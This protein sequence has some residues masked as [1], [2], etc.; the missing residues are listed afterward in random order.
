MDGK[1]GIPSMTRIEF[2]LLAAAHLERAE[3]SFKGI[4]KAA[5]LLLLNACQKGYDIDQLMT[6]DD[7]PAMVAAIDRRV[8][9]YANRPYP[10]GELLRRRSPAEGAAYFLA[11]WTWLDREGFRPSLLPFLEAMVE[12]FAPPPSCNLPS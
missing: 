1:E 4:S 11:V 3:P 9:Y 8:V 10:Y 2:F 7:I 6:P 5:N 12:P